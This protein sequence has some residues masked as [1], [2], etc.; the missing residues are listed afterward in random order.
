MQARVCAGRCAVIV[1]V[2]VA[3]LAVHWPSAMRKRTL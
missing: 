3:R 1:G 2:V